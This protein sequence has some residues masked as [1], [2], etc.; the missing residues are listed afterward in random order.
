MLETKR[1]DERT[2]EQ[3]LQLAIAWQ[4]LGKLSL[5]IANCKKAIELQP[6]YLPAA[7]KL[8]DLLSRSGREQPSIDIYRRGIETAI[9]KG[10]TAPDRAR[11]KYRQEI[12]RRSKNGEPLRVLLYTN[13][14]RT[15]GVEQVSHSIARDLARSGHEVI[16][17]QSKE[18]HDLIHE[19]NALGIEHIWLEDDAYRFDYASG[20]ASEVA[21]ILASALPDLVI[22][23][24]GEIGDNIAAHWVTMELEIPYLWVIHRVGLKRAEQ[25]ASYLGLLPDLYREARAIVSVSR[26]NLRLLRESFGLPENLGETIYNGRPAEYF[27]P[28]GPGIRERIRSALDIP[29]EAVIVF[30]SAR[31]DEEKGYQHQIAAIERLQ[32][33]TVWSRLYFVWAGSGALEKRW[34]TRV[35]KVG[36]GS[37]VKFLGRRSDIPDLLDAAD[38]FLLPSHI[39]GMPLAIMEAMAK[40]LPVIA[41]AISGIP[42]ELGDTGKL[43]SDPTLDPTVTVQEIV[44][45][46]QAWTIDREL[47]QNIGRRCQ[48]RA[49]A[50]FR[51]ERM[52][53]SYVKLI[54]AAIDPRIQSGERPR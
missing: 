28:S 44:E 20:N 8:I 42:E 11:E 41:T 4:N 19:R 52:V 22:F 1:S 6:D 10:W 23:A 36:A 34:K 18:D 13:C 29:P 43:L 9:S 48:Q 3:Q 27:A 39:E 17:V 14:P 7:I 37:R 35:E 26:D 51:E 38:I 40:G 31:L 15:Y 47:R 49:M 45:T 53:E 12:A 50:M 25:Y 5:A 16:C 54:Q 30:T 32:K 21:G 2:A 46:I 33:R 24:D